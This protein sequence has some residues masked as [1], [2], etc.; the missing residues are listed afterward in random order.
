MAVQSEI[1][2]T[3]GTLT[4]RG[5]VVLRDVPCNVSVKPI[6]DCTSVFV[7][8]SSATPFSRCVFCLG[9]LQGFRVLSLFRFKIWW[10]IPF[11]GKSGKDIPVESQMVLLEVKTS[12]NASNSIE[13]SVFYVLFLPTLDGLFRSSLQGNSEEHLELCI[14]SGD[15]DVQTTQSLEA[16][17]VNAGDDPYNLIED[18]VKIL[19]KY[20]GT[21]AHRQNKKVPGIVDWFGWCTWDAFY[22]DV[23]PQG[24]H[25][26]LQSLIEG[27]TPARFLI[28]DDGWQEIVNPIK[29]NT[30]IDV[31]DESHFVSRLIDTRE[32]QKFRKA[33]GSYGLSEVVSHVKETYRLKY[34][35][36]WHA[37]LGYWGGV[38]PD[39][40]KMLK[41]G[42][43]MKAPI[44]SPG[45]VANQMDIAMQSLQKY[46][47]GFIGPDR[48]PELYDDYHSYLAS[49]GIDGVK[50]DVQGVLETL[51]S[52]LG[53]RVSLTQQ[54]QRV[55]EDSVAKYFPDNACIACMS[56]NSDSFYNSKKT[57][58]VRACEDFMP[59]DPLSQTVFVASVAYNSL[60]LGEFM[61]PDWDM[62]HSFHPAAEYHAAARSI[63]GYAV[64]VSDKPENHE[65]KILKKLVFPDGSIL[66]AKNPGRPTRDSLFQDVTGDRKSLLKIWNMNECTGILGILN[67]QGATWSPE[68]HCIVA[69]TS[70]IPE[71]ISGKVSP[72]DIAGIKEFA[73]STPH[74]SGG[75]A[76]FAHNA[77]ELRVFPQD[78]E[79]TSWEVSLGSYG[80]ELFIVAPIQVRKW[81]FLLSFQ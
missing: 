31:T 56:H 28:I 1:E 72:T 35:Y 55:L 66:R 75:F 46:G 40:P 78:S 15:A 23:N 54:Y 5:K 74:W 8:A 7:G 68:A 16:V 70:P 77:G 9:T 57:A 29:P 42:A 33:D 25:Q 13:G 6:P 2:I 69:P 21:F 32:N 27:G 53:G 49:C 26:G 34:V 63:G 81:H 60:L 24:I 36:V 43:A 47:V 41:Y 52:G 64:Y 17:L 37:L 73:S 38:L 20:K 71:K 45:A 12:V 19:E 50:A 10:M 18:S 22:T 59:R 4:V 79:T 67:C 80:S 51:G 76:L 39:A 30:H 48:I 61:Q 44:Q 62:F 11:V 3:E 58:I 65:F 14:E